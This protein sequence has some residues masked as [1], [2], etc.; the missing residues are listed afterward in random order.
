MANETRYL[1]IIELFSLVY[2][3]K[4]GSTLIG[5]AL[6]GINSSDLLSGSVLSTAKAA[7]T[8]SILYSTHRIFVGRQRHGP[9]I[10]TMRRWVI[11]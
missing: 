3:S 2:S 9:L 4:I 6:N 1:K 5:M 7:D 11:A 8:P 10:Y